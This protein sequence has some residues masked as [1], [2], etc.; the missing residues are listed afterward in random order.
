MP[1]ESETK[2]VPGE[3]ETK[4]VPG[5]SETKWVPGESETTLMNLLC[6]Q[7]FGIDRGT[8]RIK[9]QIYIQIHYVCHHGLL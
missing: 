6:V 7:S 4:W 5:E 1:G 2:W 9:N 3:S 8:I